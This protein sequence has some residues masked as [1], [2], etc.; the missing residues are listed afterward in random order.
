M[1][2]RTGAAR[3]GADRRSEAG[4]AP[5]RLSYV[6]AR[7]DRA[8]RREIDDRVRPHG[9][10]IARYTALSVLAS[11]DGLS[12]AQLARRS[13]ITPQSMSQVIAALERDG[14]I[15]RT[16]D[17]AHRRIQRARLTR[18][19]RRVMAAC[20]AAV[21]TLEEEM[22]RDVPPRQRE[23]LAAQLASCVRRLGAGLGSI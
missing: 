12:N 15:E 2:E 8:L 9:L 7:L 5:R 1:S 22:L 13:Y 4:A 20:D 23:L 18:K 3:V 17:P 16:P 14:L 6:I 10:T 11:R 21:G 19:G